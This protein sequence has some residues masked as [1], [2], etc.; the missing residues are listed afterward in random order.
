MSA[1]S[2]TYYLYSSFPS[3]PK[4]VGQKIKISG[5]NAN[6]YNFISSPEL[7]LYYLSVGTI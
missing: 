3:D 6:I 2:T 1:K 4:K 5:H 7:I